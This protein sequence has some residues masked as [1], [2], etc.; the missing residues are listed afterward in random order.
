M[1]FSTPAICFAFIF[2][3]GALQAQPNLSTKKKVDSLLQILPKVNGIEKARLLARL[4]TS[5]IYLNKD[6]SLLLTNQAIEQF[7]K[8]KNEID[9]FDFLV[10]QGFLISKN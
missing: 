7:K 8:A 2:Y 10:E 9:L 6:S 5:I 4:S 1:K 3:F